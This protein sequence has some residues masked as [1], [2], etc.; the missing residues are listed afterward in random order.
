MNWRVEMWCITGTKDFAKVL[1]GFMDEEGIHTK[2]EVFPASQFVILD[3]VTKDTARTV[4]DWALDS[5]GGIHKVEL[6]K[7]LLEDWEGES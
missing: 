3:N 1:Q 2:L 5:W 6:R 7:N 4:M